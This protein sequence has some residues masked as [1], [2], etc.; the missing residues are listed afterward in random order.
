MIKSILTLLMLTSTCLAITKDKNPFSLKIDQETY[1]TDKNG[2]FIPSSILKLVPGNAVKIYLM[3]GTELKGLIKS[4]EF[5]NSEVFKVFGEMTNKDNTGFGFVFT[6][7]AIFGGAVVFRDKNF[8]YK[9]NYN[10]VAKGYVLM[11]EKS[12]KIGS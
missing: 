3:D 8:V 2:V 4:T 1:L 11:L 7:D 5:I 12:E 6:R 9:I 10:E